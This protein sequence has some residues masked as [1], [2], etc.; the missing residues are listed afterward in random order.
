MSVSYA[1]DRLQGLAQLWL[2]ATSTHSALDVG[3][4]A[5]LGSAPLLLLPLGGLIAERSDRRQ[6]LRAG[7]LVGAAATAAV[8][9]LVLTHRLAIWHIYAWTVVN[10]FI[11]L[12]GRPAYKALLTEVVPIDEAARAVALNAMAETAALVAVNGL[13]GILLAQFGLKVATAEKTA[14]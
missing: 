3:V 2:V 12:V 10:G 8:G 4:L 13:G 7:Q 5:A 1:G 14:N 9:A 11:W 6:L